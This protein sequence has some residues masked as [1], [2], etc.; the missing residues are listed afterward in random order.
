MAVHIQ[1]QAHM[2]CMRIIVTKLQT[3]TYDI[4]FHIAAYTLVFTV[5]N[6]PSCF[7]ALYKL[8]KMFCSLA[9]KKMQKKTWT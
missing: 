2:A 6:E 4:A 5:F 1:Q 9:I 8:S 3:I 7:L